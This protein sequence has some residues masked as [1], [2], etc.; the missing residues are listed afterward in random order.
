MLFEAHR[1]S[2][3]H[4]NTAVTAK[5][6]ARRSC[7]HGI[8]VQYCGRV[9]IVIIVVVV[10]LIIIIIVIV[11]SISISIVQKTVRVSHGLLLLTC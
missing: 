1:A 2:L 8:V 6:T 7:T 4:D 5:T 9:I 10:V 3:T 11:I